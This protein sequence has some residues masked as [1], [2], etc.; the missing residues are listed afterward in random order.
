M[1]IRDKIKGMKRLFRKW[2]LLRKLNKECSAHTISLAINALLFGAKHVVAK[3]AFL[4]TVTRSIK[5]E[6]NRKRKL[7]EYSSIL[8]ESIKEELVY[9]EQGGVPQRPFC[10]TTH[11]GDKFVSLFLWK[12][13]FD[14][15]YSKGILIAIIITYATLRIERIFEPPKVS[16]EPPVVNI[17]PNITSPDVYPTINVYPK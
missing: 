15:A 11:T 16:V 13:F 3:D 9:T 8:D 5:S 14:N 6:N 17:Y 10:R 1:K 12:F 2:W 4:D 7:M